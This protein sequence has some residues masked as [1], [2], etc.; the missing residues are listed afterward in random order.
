MTKEGTNKWLEDLKKA[1]ETKDPQAAADLCSENVRYF[2]DPFKGPLNKKQFLEEWK[3]VPKS[4]KNIIFNYKIL[5]VTD[6]LGIAQWTAEFVRLPANTKVELSGIF[7]IVLDE[8]NL[9]T[10]FHQWWNTK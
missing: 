1:W 10:E 7:T 4:Q 3:N 9:C 6:N 2:E 8:N 5:S